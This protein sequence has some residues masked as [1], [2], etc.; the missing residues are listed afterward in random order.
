M[1][2]LL[3]FAIAI[4]MF[5]ISNASLVI[6]NGLSHEHNVTPGS[7]TQGS[8]IIKNTA[9]TS[10]RAR[11]YKTDVS[12]D[13]N[14]QTAFLLESERDR[15]NSSWTLLSDNEI[16]IP[17]QQTYTLTYELSPS[18]E[19]ENSGSYWGVI[20]VE[21]IKDLDTLTPQRGVTVTSLI[22]Y[23]VQI[24]THFENDNVK[25][26]EITSVKM[27]TTREQNVLSVSVVNKGNFMLKPIMFVEL[28]D[29]TGVQIYREEIPYQKVYPGLCKLFEIP[30]KG[31]PMGTYNGVLVADCGDESLFGIEMELT[32]PQERPKQ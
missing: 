14:G 27:D 2:Q 30:I 26:L 5:Q 18:S 13:C 16:V 3:A 8:I 22:R 32:V 25:D 31:V 11:I 19:I 6:V 28:Y 17:S 7:K 1:K 20:M 21:E 24:V 12:H 4:F 10:K 9:E 29:E 15:C 23:A